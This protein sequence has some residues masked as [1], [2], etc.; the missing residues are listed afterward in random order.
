MLIYKIVK[1][2]IEDMQKNLLHPHFLLKNAI[3]L[4]NICKNRNN[5]NNCHSEP[6]IVGEE[7]Y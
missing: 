5:C 3:T 4:D 7:S 6:T 1:Y 2:Y